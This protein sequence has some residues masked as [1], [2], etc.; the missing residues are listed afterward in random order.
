MGIF[1][2]GSTRVCGREVA[3]YSFRVVVLRADGTL[4][5]F[6]VEKTL[7]AAVKV[8]R[9]ACSRHLEKLRANRL[10]WLTDSRRPRTVYVQ[11]WS[12]TAVRG[13][14]VDVP[15]ARGGYEFTFY[16]HAP[17]HRRAV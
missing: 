9:A 2:G 15:R 6:R 4:S 7:T 10:M 13:T 3:I 1:N 14:W 5:L 8:A 16:D 17:S 12:G 11:A